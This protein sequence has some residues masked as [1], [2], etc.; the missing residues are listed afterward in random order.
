MKDKEMIARLAKRLIEIAS[1]KKIR[2]A[3]AE[4]CTGGMIAQKITDVPGSSKC[5]SHGVVSYSDEAKSQFFKI[6]VDTL[7]DHGAVSQVVAEQMAEGVIHYND[8]DISVAVTG[9]AGPSGATETKSIGTVWFSWAKKVEKK[10]V[11]ESELHQFDGNR[12]KIRMN[13]TE[14][15]LRGIENRLKFSKST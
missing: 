13:A 15:A 7:K 4:S 3:V 11:I 1:E 5:F 9:I 14:V 2:I 8:C 10:I 6:K 12:E